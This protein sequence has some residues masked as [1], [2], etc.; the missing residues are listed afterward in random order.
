VGA[1]ETR[2]GN[3]PRDALPRG[4]TLYGYEIVGF[5][6]R[7]GFG[8]TYRAVDRINQVFA[9]KECLPRQFAVR[10]ATTVM[11]AD[12]EY[13]GE[14]FAKCLESFTKEALALTRFSKSGAAGDGV[15][16][17]ITSFETNGT[18]YI[19]M[20]F[21]E[22]DS[23]ERLIGAYPDGLPE[24]SLVPIF[25]GLTNTLA[26]VH[27]YDLLHRDIKPANLILRE[28]G[29]PVLLDFGAARAVRADGPMPSQ[30]FT[31][32][33]A[34]IEQI[35]G[36]QQG[37][38]SDLYSMGVTCYQAVAG[39]AFR[40]APPSSDRFRAILRREPDPL[41]PA[42][43]I[44]AGRYQESLLRAIDVLLRVAPEDRPQN[45]EAFLPYLAEH[46][47]LYQGL[48]ATR[49]VL[50]PTPV[51]D[52]DATRSAS[53]A[54]SA[55]NVG[56][57]NVGASNAARTAD[58][59]TAET[60]FSAAPSA[61]GSGFSRGTYAGGGSAMEA[62][63]VFAPGAAAPA[64]IAHGR[65]GKSGGGA[66]LAV[67]GVVMLLLAGAI[68]GG[69]YWFVNH[70][71]QDKPAASASV[72]APSASAPSAS[73]PSASA[74][75]VEAFAVPPVASSA[76]PAAAKTLAGANQAY[77]QKDF[78]GALPGYQ[79][80]AQAGDAEAQYHLGYMSQLGQGVPVDP[81]VALRWYQKAAAQ[82]YA[83]AQSQI[84]YLY[85][86]GIGVPQ[87]YAAAAHWYS[88]AA[89]QGFKTAELQLGYLSQHGFGTPRNYS[90]ALHWYKL[91][92]DQG[93]AAAQNQMGYL[94]QMGYGVHMNYT[95]AFG[96]YKA[97]ADQG[98]PA[99]EYTVGRFYNEG[100][101]I[102]RD[103]AAARVWMTKAAAGGNGEASAW[104]ASH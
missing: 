76:G 40:G 13:A 91:A 50:R 39:A 74:A 85:Q 79:T 87:D 4:T 93:S 88:L 36:R 61:P 30:I 63:T 9:L 65:A 31:E 34:P 70:K 1:A 101:G 25:R 72:S 14:M 46:E 89:A 24:Q 103:P 7:G 37:P 3:W 83:P 2:A 11:P 21:I 67:M 49:I 59:S 6:G 69:A 54:A 95:Q 64:T 52:A 68:G 58:M 48:E 66:G 47:A 82:N 53:L 81:V 5:L 55:A 96:Y 29:R 35:E 44:G 102:P 98:L 100:L 19:V 20:E 32:T 97:A 10:E 99:A 75:P 16:K 23:L 18:A 17:V 15:V 73:A 45:V 41:V 56:A 38:F 51:R 104:L 33:Y 28:D 12:D 71:T 62:A 22:G 77:E 86:Y 80:A 94:Y 26:C 92:A 84:G 78:G 42:V 27:G 57:A 43:V 90:A 8:I 60:V